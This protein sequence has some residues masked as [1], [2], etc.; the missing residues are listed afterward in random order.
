MLNEMCIL[1]ILEIRKKLGS[2][3][4]TQAEMYFKNILNLNYFC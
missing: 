1:K 4:S 3:A 2:R